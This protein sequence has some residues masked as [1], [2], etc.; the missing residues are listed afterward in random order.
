MVMGTGWAPF[1][2]GPLHYA[3]ALGVERLVAE[4]SRLADKAGPAFQPCALLTEM[5][6]NQKSFYED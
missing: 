5:A 3:D 1:R 2:G 4:L 6:R